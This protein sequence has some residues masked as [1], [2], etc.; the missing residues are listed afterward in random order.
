MTNALY[1]KDT[2]G[3]MDQHNPAADAAEQNAGLT[4]RAA[5][6][7]QSGEVDMIGRIH[8]DIFFQQRY[9]LNEVNTKI[10]LI[11]SKDS[12]CLMASANGFKVKIVSA[13]L[14]IRKV[15]ISPSVYLA[16]AK[17]LERGLAKYPI[18]RVICKSFT[19]P[20]GYLDISQE[21]V[22]SGQLPSRLIVGCVDNRAYNGRGAHNPFNF[23]HYD[24]NEI[25]V[26]LD[27]QQH[28]IK[29]LSVDYNSKQY[30]AAYMSLFAGTGKDGRN[31]GND[32]DRTEF[33]NGYSL[34]VFDLSPDLTDDDTHFN[35]SRQG[36]VRLNMKFAKSLPETV[37]VVVY[38]EFENIIEIDRSRNVVF[39]FN[40]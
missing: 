38:G 11:R 34:Y 25:S 5:F 28:G 24:L 21:K 39:D 35:L 27:G 15:K 40:N 22:F 37:T 17:A 16:H 26:F 4:K 2:A 33:A 18:R 7:A 20:K 13:Y 9:M 19:I 3:K 36:T 32:I 6:T 29:P 23:K 14:L 12:F 1:Y 10:K 8:S 31:V 30:A